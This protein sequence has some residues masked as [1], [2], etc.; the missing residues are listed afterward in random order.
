MSAPNSPAILSHTIQSNN[1]NNLIS[2][3]SNHPN[4]FELSHLEHKYGYSQFQ[5]IFSSPNSNIYQSLISSQQHHSITNNTE[6]INPFV[7]IKLAV[8]DVIRGIIPH[9]F[10]LSSLSHQYEILQYLYKQQCP[11][12]PRPINLH[13]IYDNSNNNNTANPIH[14]NTAL[15]TEYFPGKSLAQL[16][17]PNN[18]LYS[19]FYSL[20]L[21]DLLQYCIDMSCIL[22]EIHS[23]NVIH[24]DISSA[25]ILLDLDSKQ[26][27]IID[28]DLASPHYTI[29]EQLLQLIRVCHASDPSDRPGFPSILTVLRDVQDALVIQQTENN[30]QQKSP[31]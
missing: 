15:V 28:F 5:L 2:R 17:D 12:I 4:E 21:I 18:P 13:L 9:R 26:V 29:P 3:I 19:Q 14:I 10:Q 16:N 24:K 25:N 11:G 27:R 6:S 23:A 7:S 22:H 31:H 20:N 8:R 30:N 1:N